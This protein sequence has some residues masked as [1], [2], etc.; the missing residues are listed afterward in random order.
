VNALIQHRP[1][2]EDKGGIIARESALVRGIALSAGVYYVFTASSTSIRAE[3][4]WQ[5]RPSPRGDVYVLILLPEWF[6]RLILFF[7]THTV[8]RVKVVGRDNFPDKTGALLVCNHM[9]FVIGAADR[10]DGQADSLPH[11]QGHLRSQDREAVREDDEGH[12]HLKRA[13]ARDMI[14]SLQ[15]AARLC[16][17]TRWCASSPKGRSRAP[18]V[19]SLPPRP[20]THYE[21]H[22]RSHH[23]RESGRSVGSIFSSSRTV[24]VEDAARIPYP[25]T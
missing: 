19:A 21:G 25:V 13:A 16:A 12:S 8:Y 11:V 14:R 5:P 1:R 4:S 17:R 3:S 6:G 24:S 9:S 18:A 22:R 2:E 10:L 20:G 7:V 15:T 23:S